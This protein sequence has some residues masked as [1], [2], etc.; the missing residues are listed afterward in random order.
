MTLIFSPVA[1]AAPTLYVFSDNSPLI[2]K[3]LAYVNPLS[4]QLK[5]LRTVA[6]GLFNVS[7]LLIALALTVLMIV[8][9]QVILRRMPL[10]LAER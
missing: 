4:Y 3:I 6:F 9:A 5:A 8:F 10:S 2:I 1:Y 7:D